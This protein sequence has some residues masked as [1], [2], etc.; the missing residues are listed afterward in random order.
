[1]GTRNEILL[2][3]LDESGASLHMLLTRL[4]LREE[5]AEELMQELF[6]QLGSSKN[7]HKVKNLN[8]YAYRAAINIAC[9]W[10]RKNKRK[11]VNIDD[12][13]EPASEEISPLDKA[14]QKEQFEVVLNAIGRL[15]G[16]SR[17]TVV[18]RYIQQQSYESISETLGKTQNQARALCHKG[19]K[20]IRT[21]MARDGNLVRGKDS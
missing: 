9:D 21:L 6:T 8:A 7:L 12:I 5:L 17:Q 18:M 15:K 16:L 1:M 4:T 2:E 11:K 14:I 10:W 13:N 19:L 3:L 20:N